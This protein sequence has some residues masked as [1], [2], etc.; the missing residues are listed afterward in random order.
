MVEL[1]SIFL[2]IH[3][4]GGITWYGEVFFI[5]FVLIPTLGRLPTDAKGPLMAGIFPRI[6]NVAT[7]TSSVTIVAGATTALLY[8]NFDFGMFLTIPWGL[9]IL[10]G[11]AMGLCLLSPG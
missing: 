3:I 1:L 10:L 11:G 2:F 7:V 4:F 6:F 5:T 9:S 8:S